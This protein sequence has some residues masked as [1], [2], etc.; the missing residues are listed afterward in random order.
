M[1]LSF[2]FLSCKRLEVIRDDHVFSLQIMI[3]CV[4][5]RS[6]ESNSKTAVF[7]VFEIFFATFCKGFDFRTC[8]YDYNNFDI[9]LCINRHIRGLKNINPS[10]SGCIIHVHISLV[11]TTALF[12][13]WKLAFPL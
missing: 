5:G 2:V 1:W 6:L 13:C 10:F 8:K 7:N 11:A 4:L 3:R 12:W 9:C